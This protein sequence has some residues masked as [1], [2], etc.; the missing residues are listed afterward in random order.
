MKGS[1]VSKN[2]KSS[3]KGECQPDPPT[4]I[5]SIVYN[6]LLPVRPA[7]ALTI[8]KSQGQTLKK[9]GVWLADNP[10]FC[11]GNIHKTRQL[12]FFMAGPWWQL[13]W[14]TMTANIMTAYCQPW[15]KLLSVL[16]P[17]W[18]LNSPC[19]KVCFDMETH[20]CRGSFQMESLLQR[21]CFHMETHCCRGR[22][23]IVN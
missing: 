17:L 21:E 4:P 16:V 14:D 5:L 23:L 19:I 15:L 9:V 18:G 8:N 11:H 7:F 22:V 6:N 2:L 20:C 13:E 12:R 1:L 10:C 3:D